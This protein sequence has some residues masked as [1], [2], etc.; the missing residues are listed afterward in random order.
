MAKKSLESNSCTKWK[1]TLFPLFHPEQE[2]EGTESFNEELI[3]QHDGDEGN[4][5]ENKILHDI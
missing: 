4:R 3:D 5:A 2:A 1:R